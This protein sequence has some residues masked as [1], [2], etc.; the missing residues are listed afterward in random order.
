M[1]SNDTLLRMP[2]RLCGRSPDELATSVG[3]AD[4]GIFA[5]SRGVHEAGKRSA[6]APQVATVAVV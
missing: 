2:G 5:V 3:W 6:L 1:T 4:H